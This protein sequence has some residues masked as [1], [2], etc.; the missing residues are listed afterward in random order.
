MSIGFPLTDL[1]L[2]TA[3][4]L[5]SKVHRVTL[6]TLGFCALAPVVLGAVVVH[7]GVVV[8]VH[9]LGPLEG[10]SVSLGPGVGTHAVL[11]LTEARVVL[12]HQKRRPRVLEAARVL[13]TVVIWRLEL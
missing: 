6:G 5:S 2:V 13:L 3:L 10:D 7:V 11:H 9:R 4:L 8:A 1:V 12:P